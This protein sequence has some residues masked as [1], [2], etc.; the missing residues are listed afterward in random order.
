M[1]LVLKN[2]WKKKK[3]SKMLNLGLLLVFQ[4]SQANEK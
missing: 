3:V 2:K 4:T 1:L